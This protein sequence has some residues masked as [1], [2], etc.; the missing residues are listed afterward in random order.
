MYFFIE[1]AGATL[2]KIELDF[3]AEDLPSVEA[4]V[5]GNTYPMVTEDVAQI[6]RVTDLFDVTL[7]SGVASGS[8]ADLETALAAL[9]ADLLGA[10]AADVTAAIVTIDEAVTDAG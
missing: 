9:Y 10:D 7:T 2:P 3:K 5:C 1:V 6:A 8:R 4:S